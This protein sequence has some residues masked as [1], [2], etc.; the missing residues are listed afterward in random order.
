[1]FK[2]QVRSIC[3]HAHHH[4]FSPTSHLFDVPQIQWFLAS[5]KKNHTKFF[6]YNRVMQSQPHFIQNNN[7]KSNH[8]GSH[9]TKS[10]I[11]TQSN[12]LNHQIHLLKPPKQ[13]IWAILSRLQRLRNW[14]SDHHFHLSIGH[15]WC[16]D[17]YGVEIRRNWQ[18]SCSQNNK[19]SYLTLKNSQNNKMWVC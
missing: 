3:Q 9:R 13:S 14:L 1:M 6:Q 4:T 11:H 12:T 5:R 8:V 18:S 17:R 16:F 10:V 2:H 15:Y 7:K 19:R